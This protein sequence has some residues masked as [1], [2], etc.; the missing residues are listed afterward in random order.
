MIERLQKAMQQIDEIP[1][2]L[3]DQ[4]AELIESAAP[5]S[6]SQRTDHYFGIWKDLDTDDM[7][8]ELDR[9]RHE[10]PPTPLLEEQ[11]S[12]LDEDENG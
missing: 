2:E 4:I 8:G 5:S 6:I 7:L 3:Q 9:L 10:V 1:L 11:L 12:W